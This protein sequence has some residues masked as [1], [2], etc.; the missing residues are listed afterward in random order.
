MRLLSEGCKAVAQRR[1]CPR[2]RGA[3]AVH[4]SQDF[5][6]RAA[7]LASK[8]EFSECDSPSGELLKLKEERRAVYPQQGLDGLAKYA[9][10]L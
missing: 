3:R 7:A 4:H 1:S 6:L 10:D 8:M 5:A 9:P 2:L